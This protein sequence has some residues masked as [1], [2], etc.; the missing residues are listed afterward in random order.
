MNDV[1]IVGTT[2]SLSICAVSE[3][4]EKAINNIQAICTTD[5]QIVKSINKRFLFESREQI[6]RNIP[7]IRESTVN[8]SS[9]SQLST[10]TLL[11]KILPIFVSANV[12]N[13]RMN[14]KTY[15]HR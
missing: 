3:E 4:F 11:T 9:N 6:H 15:D 5:V 7:H 1:M 13:E 14:I 8:N 2:A 12:E 10:C